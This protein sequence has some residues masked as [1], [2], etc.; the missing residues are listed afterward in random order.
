MKIDRVETFL[1]APRWLFVRIETDDGMVGWGEATLESRCEPVAAAIEVFSEYLLGEDPTT[2]E[3]HWQVLSKSGFY[4]GGPVLSSAVAGVDQAL[5]DLLGKSLGVPVHVLLGGAVRDRVR[6]YSWIGGDDPAEIR[7]NASQQIEAGFTAVK[8]NAAGVL[9]ALDTSAAMDKTLGLAAA[10]RDVMGPDGDF[11]LDFHGRFST[12]M[13]RRLVSELEPYRPLFV[14]EPVLPEYAPH[15]LESV[16]RS[17]SIPI[18]AGERCY[19]RT[20]FLPLLRAGLAIAQPDLAH[21]GGISEGRRIATLAETFDALLAPH[22]PIGPLGLAASLQVSFTSPN[23]LIQEQSMGIH[24]NT[25]AELLDYLL[26][27]AVFDFRDGHCELPSRPGLGVD[28][29]EPAVRRAANSPH[30]WR[31]PVWFR[32]DGSMA[33]W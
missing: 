17:T 15:T 20:D 8:M 22:C 30:S 4:R 24:Y 32:E 18:A 33:E 14:E 12:A 29:D 11:A 3:K 19:N 10:A 6:V 28:I 2:I 5:W 25:D 23:F 9:R 27:T 31:G 1:V 13:A 21:C 26:D 7:D 16:I